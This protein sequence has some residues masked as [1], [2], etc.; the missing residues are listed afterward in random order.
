MIWLRSAAFAAWFHGLTTLM[1]LAFAPLRWLPREAARRLALGYARGWARLVLGGLRVLCG[2]SWQASGLEQVPVD[3]PALIASLHQSA[4][5]TLIWAVLRPR[6]TYVMK[7]ELLRIPLF[8]AM[9]ELTGMIPIDRA[10]GAASLR[11]LL[12][13]ADRA[14]AE[15]RQIVIFPQGTRVA[16]GQEIRLL[17]GVAALAAR[18]GLPVFPVVTDSGRHWGRRGFRKPAGVIHLRVLPPLPAGLAREELLARLRAAL[19][20][21]ADALRDAVDNPV[22]SGA[23]GLPPHA[24]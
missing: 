7:R 20:E 24:S 11:G 2:V 10:G 4:F 19:A 23:P 3:G 21:G 8:G 16:P 1:L 13:A 15:R 14:V 5:D 18:T 12:R 6:F 17:P 9:L 22:G